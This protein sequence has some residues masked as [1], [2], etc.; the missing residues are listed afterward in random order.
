M[1]YTPSL[2]E[3]SEDSGFQLTNSSSILQYAATPIAT[4]HTWRKRKL[5]HDAYLQQYPKETSDYE[6]PVTFD[7]D[8]IK[9]NIFSSTLN[10]SLSKSLEKCDLG[11]YTTNFYVEHSANEGSQEKRYKLDDSPKFQP[12]TRS[13]PSTPTKHLE[14]QELNIG[15]SRSEPLGGCYFTPDIN[16]KLGTQEK[17][18][19]LYP[20]IQSHVSPAKVKTPEKLREF[21]KKVNSPAKKRL[22]D[23][24]QVERRSTDPI[25]LFTVK[26]DFR[27]IVGKIF[28]YLSELDLCS[29][30]RVSKVWR[31][32][33]H[34]DLKAFPRCYTYS[35]EFNSNK[36]N[37]SLDLCSFVEPGIP[38]LS[39]ETDRFRQ[40]TKIASRLLPNQSLHKCL[41]CMELAVIQ[42]SISQCQ[43]PNC[44]Y[45]YCT[46]CLSFSLTGPE[47]FIDKCHMSELIVSHNSHS[48]KR[49]SLYDISNGTTMYMAPSFLT[50]ETQTNFQSKCDSSGYISECDITPNIKRNLGIVENQPLQPMSTNKVNNIVR[51]KIRRSSLVSVVSARATPK[52][53]ELIEPSSP[54]KV[55][56]I[57]GSKQSKKNLKRLHF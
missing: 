23:Y 24:Y 51:R 49:S 41:R 1:D 7:T 50:N 47:N 16:Y 38:P 27:H 9:A 52:I 42:K 32:A 48:F 46:N 22:F 57:A 39:P 45:I 6:S 55:K 54:P 30:S 15:K 13:A 21:L 53:I 18:A 35:K 37:I 56:N 40:C 34:S 12:K 20:N 31:R 44:Q 4:H 17:L 14:E 8:V 43:N 28:E 19:L 5:L 25:L 26:N 10:E 36:E 3:N 29:V 2:C 33:L 11:I